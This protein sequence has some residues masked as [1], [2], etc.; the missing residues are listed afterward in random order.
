MKHGVV[1][2]N[3]NHYYPV[4][5]NSYSVEYK[6]SVTCYHHYG[7]PK[8]NVAPLTNIQIIQIICF[9]DLSFI[10]LQKGIVTYVNVMDL[11]T[12]HE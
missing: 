5:D 2:V 11:K 3:V 12:V 1:N 7:E 6:N 4:I 8:K 10:L 9:L